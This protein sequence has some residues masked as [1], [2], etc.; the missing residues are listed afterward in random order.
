MANRIRIKRTGTVSREPSTS[1][2]LT[3]ELALNY[4]EGKLYTLKDDGTQSVITIG[5]DLASEG[6]A[7]RIREIVG[8]TDT[9]EPIGFPSRADTTISFSNN[10][11]TFTIAPV[12]ASFDVWCK[13]KKYS[14]STAQSVQINSATGLYYIYFNNTGVLSYRT[15]YFDWEND[16]PTAYIYWNSSTSTAVYF[17][18]ERHG[19]TLDWATHEYL[20]RTRGAALASGFGVSNY[21]LLGDGSLDSDAQFNLDDGIFFDEDIEVAIVHRS[22]PTPN[23]WEQYLRGPARVPVL[24]LTGTEWRI[25]TPSDFALKAGTVLPQYNLLTEST[26]STVDAGD[27]K[28]FNCYIVATNNLNYPVVSVLGQQQFDNIGQTEDESFSS[29]VLTGFPSFEF[30]PLYKL[31]FRTASS[32]TNSIKA[33]LKAVTDIRGLQSAGFV[34]ATSGSSGVSD[35]GLLTGTGDDD[36]LQYLHVTESRSNVTANISTS[37]LLSTTNTTESTSSSSGAL[38][39]SGGA[40]VGGNLYVGGDFNVSGNIDTGSWNA[41]VILS[42]YGGTGFA[43][44]VEGDLLTGAANSSLEKT[45]TSTGAVI[46][47]VGT[48]A[49]RPTNSIPGMIRF[50]SELGEFEGYNGTAWGPLAIEFNFEGDLNTLSGVVDLQV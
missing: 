36:H 27:G 17:A 37:G 45:S 6:F 35:H 41:S 2:L 1:D 33:V 42:A 13:G 5:E 34:Y 3:G 22:T 4:S 18:D 8:I 23:T 15:S 7:N 29:L 12:I 39:V 21:T 28:Y 16:T 9:F 20:H 48:T 14:Y 43:A 49:Q 30:R 31:S 25:T 47:P 11:R 24:Y 32:Y 26:W 46:L 40:G 38:T 50:N 19:V 10:T 44:Y